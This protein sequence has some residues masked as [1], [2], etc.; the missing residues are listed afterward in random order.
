MDLLPIR[1]EQEEELIEFYQYSADMGDVSAQTAVGEL[2]KWGIYGMQK[3]HTRALHYFTRA[4]EQGDMN[5]ATQLGHMH[6]NGLVLARIFHLSI[7]C[8]R[9]LALT[10]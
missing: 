9:L 2:L 4:A 8:C 5:A 7:H 10:H 3:D 1:I 6:A